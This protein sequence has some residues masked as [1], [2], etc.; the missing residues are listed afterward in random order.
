MKRL[1]YNEL[2]KWKDSER[3]KPLIVDGARQVGKTF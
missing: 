3:R 2:V 1:V